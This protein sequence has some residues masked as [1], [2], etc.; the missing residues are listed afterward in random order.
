MNIKDKVNDLFKKYGINM[1][2]EEVKLME[3]ILEDGSI[4]NTDAEVWEQGVN[5]YVIAED[6]SKTPLP[7]GEYKLADGQVLTVVTEGVVETLAAPQ[8]ME[9][10][11]TKAD[12]ADMLTSIAES[13][14]TE[15]SAVVETQKVD[16]AKMKVDFEKTITSLKDENEALKTKIARVNN[17]AREV[18]EVDFKVLPLKDRVHAIFAKYNG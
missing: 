16:F 12:V 14:R 15:L 9:K 13:V 3:A 10:T 4:I 7:A 2:A 17:P 5:V 11:Y 18:K 1:A 8:E 6:G